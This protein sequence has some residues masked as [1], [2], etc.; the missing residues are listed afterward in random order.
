MATLLKPRVI[1]FWGSGAVAVGSSGILFRDLTDFSQWVKKPSR[2]SVWKTYQQ[3]HE[4]A[5]VC[6]AGSTVNTLAY[7]LGSQSARPASPLIWVGIN[8]SAMG[9]FFLGYF[10][11]E[12]MFRERNRNALFVSTCDAAKIMKDSETAIVTQLNDT[13]EPVCFPDHQITRPHVAR[14]G[15]KVRVNSNGTTQEIPVT[16]AY[17]GL[18]GTGIVY[19]T[20][21]LPDGR[22]REF[23]PLTQLENNLVV[24]DRT[25]G[26]IGHQI[27]GLNETLLLEKLAAKEG[28]AA[29]GEANYDLVGKRPKDATLQELGVEPAQEVASWRM[30]V[31]DF[32]KAFPLGKVFV[33]DYKEFPKLAQ[34]VLSLYD[35]AIDMIFYV[36]VDLV[37]NKI[38]A[39]LFP[40]IENKDDRLPNKTRVWGLNVGDDFVAITEHWVKKGPHCTRNFTVG[41]NEEDKNYLVASWD[42][43]TESLGVWIRPS[44]QPITN[45]YINVHGIVVPATNKKKGEPEV[46]AKLERLNTVKAGLFW[47]AW[48]NFFPG[49]RLN[50]EED[51]AGTGE[52]KKTKSFLSFW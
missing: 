37:H 43:E 42:G 33:N 6:M 5:A 44:D 49:T 10:N 7:F 25:T 40:T 16:I 15:D 47:F 41:S 28:A 24:M 13:E 17:C 1:L 50:P 27:N 20:P 14:V 9:L 34:P 30:T 19:E 2:N 31:G 52:A 36:F 46:D 51:I 3:R 32:R 22:E 26:A 38:E 39:P 29:T 23:F 18:T 21:R 45:A 11:N 48:A 35:K 12:L 8:L 4:L